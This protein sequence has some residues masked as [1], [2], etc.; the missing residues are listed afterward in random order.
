MLNNIKNK[1]FYIYIYIYV[2]MDK[3]YFNYLN[4]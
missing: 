3:I 2:Y 4:V 1:L